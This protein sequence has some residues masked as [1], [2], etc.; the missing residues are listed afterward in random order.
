[1]AVTFAFFLDK[2][3]V[4]KSI[5]LKPSVLFKEAMLF[6]GA[7]LIS[8]AFESISMGILCDV[9]GMYDML[10]KALVGIF[11]II[12]NYIFSKFFIFKKKKQNKEEPNAQEPAS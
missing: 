3:L 8:G 1:C 9:F 7:R 2:L 10:A 6:Y 11:V 12:M 4:F 5:S